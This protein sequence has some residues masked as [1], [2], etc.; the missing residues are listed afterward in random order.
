MGIIKFKLGDKYRPTGHILII[1]VHPNIGL[2]Y[3]RIKKE[4]VLSAFYMN[5]SKI[6]GKRAPSVS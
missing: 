2:A 4:R 1:T 6:L 3:A 5:F